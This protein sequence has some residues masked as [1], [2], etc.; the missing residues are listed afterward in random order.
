MVESEKIGFLYINGLGDSQTTL[1]D[2]VVKWW[3]NRAGLDI[4][5]AHVNW[6]GVSLEETLQSVEQQVTEMLGMYGRVAIIGSSAGGSLAINLFYR[7]RSENICAI[8]AHG[9]VAVGGYENSH[10]MSLY[11]RAG[12]D[13]ARPSQ[14]F[15]DSVVMAERETIPSLADKEKRRL[16]VLTQLTDM[17]VPLET[18]T[19]DGVQQHRS[20]AFGHSGGFVAHLLTDRDLIADFAHERLSRP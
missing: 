19:I 14:A 9:R 5:H 7:L 12:L 17:V 20:I 3:W 2:R 18:M 4:Q 16:L 8:N 6:F 1:K 10:R 15:F 11:R 13:T